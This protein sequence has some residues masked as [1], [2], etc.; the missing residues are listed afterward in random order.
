MRPLEPMIG[1]RVVANLSALDHVVPATGLTLLRIAPDDALLLGPVGLAAALPVENHTEATAIGTHEEPSFGP[2]GRRIVAD[3]APVPH[4]VAEFGP[5]SRRI[6]V[7][8]DATHADT[9]T[10]DDPHAI[11]ERDNGWAGTW[12]TSADFH[13]QVAPFIEW[14]LP[15]ERPA[16]AQGR[17][18]GVPAKIWFEADLVLV[19][20]RATH[21]HEL[22]DRL[23]DGRND[24]ANGHRA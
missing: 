1:W 14:S 19:A 13:H 23:N 15:T 18:A 4:E 9:P 24:R 6:A 7:E 21:A 2:F 20:C 11:I 5:F 17:V 16:L 22:N 12:L 8:G 10:V 3:I